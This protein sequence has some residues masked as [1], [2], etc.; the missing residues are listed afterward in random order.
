MTTAS[1][2]TLGWFKWHW[3]DATPGEDPDWVLYEV[4]LPRDVVLRRIE[5]YPDGTAFRNS[6]ALARQG[7]PDQR[8]AEFQSLVHGKFLTHPDNAE[9]VKGLARIPQDAFNALWDRA[10]DNPLP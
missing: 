6:I 2:P 8:S 5:L 7:G 10:K 3:Q 1:S 9:W 4:D